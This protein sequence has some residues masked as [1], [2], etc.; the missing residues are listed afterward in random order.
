LEKGWV[1]ES[2]SPCV[3][4]VLLV[5]KKDGKWRMCTDCRAINNIIVKYR[6]PISRLDDMID[7][8]FGVNV[9]SKIDLKSSYH[10]IRMR[11]GDEWKIAFKTKFGLYEWLVMPF[12]LTNAPHTFMRPMN[13]VLREFIDRFIVVYFDDILV[14]SR[15]LDDHLEHLRQVLLVLRKH[16]LFANI[17]KCTFCVDSVV[18]LGFVVSKNGV[19]VD[20]EKI[21]TIQEWPTPKS[22][23]DIR[24]FHG[25]TSF[26]RRF[27][28]NFSTLALR[29]NELVKKN[30]AFT[31]GERQEKAFALLKEKLTKA[32]FLALLD[33]SKT[34]E[35]E[36]D[37][38]SVG[39]GTLLLQ[40]GHPI[41]YFSE[42]LHGATLSYPTYDKE[43]YALV[44]ALQTWKHYLVSKEVVI[45][46]D[47]ESLK[48]IRGQCKL[49]KRHAKWVEFLEQ[50]PYVIKCKKGKTNV[51]ADALSRRHTFLSSLR[52][53]ILGFDNIRELYVSDEYFS[54]IYASC[55]HK[56]QDG[57]YVDKGYLFKEGRLCISQGSIRKLLVKESYEGGLMRHLGIDKTLIFLKKKF[58]WPYMKKDVHRYCTGWWLV[59][60]PSLGLCLMGY[61]HPYLFHLHPR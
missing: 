6:H 58:F 14:Y 2:L 52:A 21:K 59:Y 26:Y 50:F 49:N 39:V 41:A 35:L 30:V 46:S 40:G 3:V 16:T 56:A 10:Q 22:V 47:H 11:E 38:S 61:T 34:F 17:D 37:A 55:G 18:L 9:F 31:W 42:K 20:P 32:P 53:Q 28:N 36:C 4:P 5:P 15:D 7:G 33:F 13:H 25:L 12:G 29:L 24:S 27:V 45:H 60:K 8:L 51:V 57:F 1:Q 54:P 48:Y 44:R 43:L 19:H 23:G